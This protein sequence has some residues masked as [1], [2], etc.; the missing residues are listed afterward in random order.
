L[1]QFCHAWIHQ[2]LQFTHYYRH[3]AKAES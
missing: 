3:N 2:K 1:L